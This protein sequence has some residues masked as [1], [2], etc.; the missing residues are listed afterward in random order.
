MS[1]HLGNLHA[2]GDVIGRPPRDVSD[3]QHEL[4]EELGGD[5]S[6]CRSSWVTFVRIQEAIQLANFAAVRRMEL[7]P[8][9]RVIQSVDLSPPLTSPTDLR[10]G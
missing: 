9:D 2:D 3:R 5:V 1:K 8:G 7:R 4:A 10:A 6:D